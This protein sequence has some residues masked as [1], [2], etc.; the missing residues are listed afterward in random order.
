MIVLTGIAIAGTISLLMLF[1]GYVVAGFLSAETRLTRLAVASLSG[2]A[3]LILIASVVG[4]VA[5]MNGLELWLV[6]LPSLLAWLIPTTRTQLLQ[7]LRATLGDAALP[8]AL[9]GLGLLCVALLLPYFIYPDLV[10]YDGRPN[11]DSFFWCI[12]AEYLQH[13]DYLS[14]SANPAP[15]R[16]YPL[17]NHVYAI[18]SAKPAWG[19]MG[20][21]GFLTIAAGMFRRTPLEVYNFAIAAL[22]PAWI[23]TVL[24]VARR[25]GLGALN[26]WALGFVCFC[27]P[28]FVFFF[29]N[30]N[31]P[32]LLGALFSGGLWLLALLLAED[33]VQS[34]WPLLAAG[35]L[36]V[37]G[38]LC[39]Y[40]EI[41]PFA[42]LPVGLFALWQLARRMPGSGRLVG[43]LALIV[44][45]GLCLNPLTTGRAWNGF[46]NS[47]YLVR[48][49][50]HWA[51]L[52][53]PL[54]FAEYV[55]SV[56]TLA[57]SSM[58][59]LG[60]V[61]GALASLAV[62][63]SLVIL[64]REGRRTTV[65]LISLSGF[66]VLLG[67][68]LL[69]SFDYGWQKS[70]QVAAVPLAALF[71][72][73]LAGAAQTALGRP[74][75]ARWRQVALAGTMA[76]M[77]Y[78]MAGHTI[79]IV[80][81]ATDKGLTVPLLG[82]RDQLAREM[83]GQ[84]IT[85]DGATFHAGIFH[86]MWAARLF[87]RQPLVFLSQLDQAG[88]YLRDSIRLANPVP[89]A[90]GALYYVAADWARAFDYQPDSLVHDRVGALVRQHNLV[91]EQAGFY[92]NTGVPDKAGARFSL[93]IYPVADGW[94][95]FTLAPDGKP[96][97][98]CE[99][100]GQVATPA[101]IESCA[102]T[103]DADDRLVVRFPLKGGV[104]NRISAQ[105]EGG[106][107]VDPAN[108]QTQFPFLVLQVRS[109]RTTTP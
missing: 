81:S 54:D 32:N 31:L 69:K 106:P 72:M 38:V 13:H 51:N 6:W 23:L 101:S 9:A 39:S 46:W 47:V 100:R 71:P 102:A 80:K 35:I 67:Y 88:G 18:L 24:A 2:L 20:A 74:A 52:F 28:L 68:T 97:A 84:T 91:T 92:R 90:P 27:Q 33:R 16:D 7:D 49:D 26:R 40:P 70:V 73:L 96:V 45:A 109:G 87:S 61:I 98:R 58:H 10:F 1:A 30:G 4:A 34:R 65:V 11:H 107:L 50:S 62:L 108:D 93:T 17:F 85:I 64:L 21:E 57:M 12:G 5:P 79:G 78:A 60:P 43:S 41:L 36:C 77:L 25:T 42:L 37:H 3:W 14:G 59:K 44:L 48:E 66:A 53:G 83:P 105:I 94:L 63:L 76:V 29:A 22:A 99:L 89:P 56:I 103:A 55:A 95:E 104:L 15:N 19:R 82:L 75:G 8:A 86:S